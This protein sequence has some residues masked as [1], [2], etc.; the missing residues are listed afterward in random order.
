[1]E[2]A[3]RRLLLDQP[4]DAR[5]KAAEEAVLRRLMEKGLVI[6]VPNRDA[7]YEDPDDIVID[8]EG[9]PLSETVIRERR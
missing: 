2:E 7:D 9:E 3:A 5:Q 6:Q 4:P 1:M 8:V